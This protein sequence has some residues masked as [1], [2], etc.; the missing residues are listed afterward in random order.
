MK[1]ALSI[2][3]LSA[4]LILGLGCSSQSGQWAFGTSDCE[5]FFKKCINTCVKKG[6]KHRNQCLTECDKSRGMCKAL[7]I[8]GCYQ[9][10]DEKHGK[11]TAL[12]KAC[13][14]GCNK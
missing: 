14:N 5:D 2:L 9:K 3:F 7:K 6:D 8:K 12:S 1:K 13:R 10:C 11:G 4:L